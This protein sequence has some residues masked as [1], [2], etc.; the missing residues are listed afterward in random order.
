MRVQRERSREW[1]CTYR[2]N[3]KEARARSLAAG[4]SREDGSEVVGRARVDKRHST[5]ELVEARRRGGGCVRVV[6]WVSVWEEEREREARGTNRRQGRRRG[7][8]SERRPRG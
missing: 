4:L 5:L 8:W 6:A 7:A 2:L 3:G 1:V